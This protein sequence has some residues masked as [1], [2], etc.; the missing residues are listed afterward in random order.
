[1]KFCFQTPWFNTR[2]QNVDETWKPYFSPR[3]DHKLA[4]Q[5]RINTARKK[6]IGLAG[7]SLNRKTSYEQTTL[8][9]LFADKK[10]RL[11]LPE[12]SCMRFLARRVDLWNAEVVD[13]RWGLSSPDF[14]SPAQFADDLC[15]RGELRR[16]VLFAEESVHLSVYVREY[17][18]YTVTAFNAL[19][20]TK[21]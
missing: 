21:K 4:P 16:P 6:W 2:S 17:I 19:W 12:L 20:W 13:E 5:N 7:V 9:C 18:S 10:W 14:L 11:K 1:M 8:R 3:L 15:S